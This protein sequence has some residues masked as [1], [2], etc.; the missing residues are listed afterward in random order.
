MAR[1]VYLHRFVVEGNGEFPFDMLRSDACWPA[2]N[3]GG[4]NILNLAPHY[5]SERLHEKR[6]VTLCSYSEPT[7][8]RWRSFGWPVV[9]SKR[10]HAIND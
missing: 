7:E 1:K 2:S 8:G 3:A 5:R 6:K 4:D 10:E 9:E